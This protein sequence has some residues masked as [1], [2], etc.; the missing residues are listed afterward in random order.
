MN[1]TA[2]HCP[3]GGCCPKCCSVKGKK[4]KTS[5]PA[6]IVVLVPATLPPPLFNMPGNSAPCIA[7][8]PTPV[9]PGYA[10]SLVTAAPAAPPPPAAYAPFAGPPPPGLCVQD[11]VPYAV[12]PA[13]YI[14]TGIPYAGIAPPPPQE[15]PVIAEVVKAREPAPSV[16][17]PAET[18]SE[19]AYVMELKMVRT[20]PG[21]K[22]K[23]ITCP[24]VTFLEG[25][26]AVVHVG[27][28]LAL[29]NGSIDDLVDLSNSIC[30]EDEVSLGNLVRVKVSGMDQDRVQ[31]DLTVR[32]HEVD[33]ASKNGIVVVGS[34]L[35]SIHKVQLGKVVKLVLEKNDQGGPRTRIEFKVTAE[36]N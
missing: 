33:M 9:P 27:K 3:A 25:N 23:E 20:A 30:A 1:K 8:P 12:A 22:E 13:P 10:P 11:A 26:A 17:G 4:K 29:R 6:P 7:E 16:P 35:R 24:K 5:S 34:S 18:R 19:K 31:V 36:K 14:A 28:N 15:V 21:C 32:H 2:G